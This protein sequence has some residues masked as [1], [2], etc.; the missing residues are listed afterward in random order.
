MR[1]VKDP[2]LRK[3]SGVCKYGEAEGEYGKV[4]NIGAR[5]ARRQLNTNL[6]INKRFSYRKIIH[7]CD[8]AML[9]SRQ[10]TQ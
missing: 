2:V 8:K 4:D 10:F 9:Q 7:G 6:L 1:I 3:A 5:L